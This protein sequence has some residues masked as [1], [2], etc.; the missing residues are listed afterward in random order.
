MFR[1]RRAWPEVIDVE[2]TVPPGQ[3]PVVMVIERIGSFTTD[4]AGG[5]NAVLEPAGI[6]LQVH[7]WGKETGRPPASLVRTLD[8]PRSRGVVIAPLVRG[9]AQDQLER[10]LSDRPDLPR[11]HVCCQGSQGARVQGDNPMGMRLI[12]HHLVQERGA[13]RVLLV[14]GVPTHPDSLEREEAIRTELARLGVPV[15]DDRVVTGAFD[16]EPAQQAVWEAL[17]REP[18][19]D[20][21]V[22]FNDRSALGAIDAAT[23]LGRQVPE[24]LLVTGF[25]DEDFAAF[26]QPSLTTVSQNLHAMGMTAGRLLLR[27]IAGETPEDARVPVLLQKRRSTGNAATP[28]LDMSPRLW[29]QVAALDLLYTLSRRFMACQTVEEIADRLSAELP[30]LGVTRTFLVLRTEDP[31]PARGTLA[32]SYYD[33][34]HHDVSR[35]EPFDLAGY[36]PRD[37]RHHLRHGSLIVQPLGIGNT[38]IGYLLLDQPLHQMSRTGEVLRMDLSRTIDT[39]RRTARLAERTL[40]LEQRTRQLE[41]EVASRTEAHLALA[42]Q[43]THDLLTGLPNRALF[44]TSADQALAKGHSRAT[45]MFVDLDRFKDV[46][47]TLGHEVGD[48]VLCNTAGRLAAFADERGGVCRLGADEFGLFITDVADLQTSMALAQSL[49]RTLRQQF[50]LAGLT[51]EIDAS[52]GVACA[53]QHGTDTASLLRM[54]DAAM[55]VAKVARCGAALYEP[56]RHQQNPHRLTLF[57]DLRQALSRGELVA[58]YQPV[59]DIAT[60]RV[61]GVEALAR[62][63]H[64]ERGMIPPSGFLDFAEQTGLIHPLTTSVLD[65][66]LADCRRW[67]DAGIPLV[68]AVNLSTRRLIDTGL[69]DEAAEMLARHRVPPSCLVFE[70]T[71]TAAMV[72]PDRA[73]SVLH[74]LRRLGVGLSIDDFGTGYASLAYLSRLPVTA[75]KIDRSFLQTMET[76]PANLTIIRSTLDLANGLGLEVIAEGVETRSAYRALAALGCQQAQGYWLARPGPATAIPDVIAALHQRLADENQPPAPTHPAVARPRTLDQH[77]PTP[78]EELPERQGAEPVRGV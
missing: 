4:M 3:G 54:A 11:V 5:V 37:L 60:G 28:P 56:D 59:I 24:D 36:L 64:P 17:Q 32:M 53:P 46:N 63:N 15:S 20:A 55:H 38:E 72:D 19:I 9:D 18:D 58:H 69:P 45:V 42:H 70:V 57:T 8:H 16:R 76:D 43:A 41:V 6:P 44:L 1:R 66:A 14:R 26:S 21:I 52:V 23:V 67:L 68:V 47:D 29:E 27:E 30:M 34:E 22:A 73:L 50:Q 7:L 48:E 12:A 33:G 77:I 74:E 78:R 65:Q 40:E 75:L 62:W 13:R 49:L 39:I 51:L 35:E 31:G 71:E 2:G 10:L 25:D 61:H